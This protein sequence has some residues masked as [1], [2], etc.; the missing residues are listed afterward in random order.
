MIWSKSV[1]WR[2]FRD[3]H[4]RPLILESDRIALLN[5][6]LNESPGLARVRVIIVTS[7]E[8]GETIYSKVVNFVCEGHNSD[9]L[10]NAG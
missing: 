10:S 6:L 5:E 3:G 1:P 7:V 9:P 2:L 4:A 8:S